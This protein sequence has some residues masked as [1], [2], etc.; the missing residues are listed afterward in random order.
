MMIYIV[1]ISLALLTDSVYAQISDFSMFS[2]L[3]MFKFRSFS[4]RVYEQTKSWLS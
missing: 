1:V 2:Y 4:D 3:N